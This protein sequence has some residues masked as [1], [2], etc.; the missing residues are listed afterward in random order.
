MS[1]P[2][3]GSGGS[4]LG[5]L[6]IGTIVLAVIVLALTGLTRACSFSPTSPSV[7]RGSVQHIDVAQAARDAARSVPFAVRAPAL[8]ADWIP[9]SSDVRPVGAGRAFRLGWVTPESG[10]VRLV[11]SNADEAALVASEEGAPQALGPVSAG[12]RTWTTYRGVRG[13]ALWV[14]DVDGVRWLLTG[15]GSPARFVQVATTTAGA[16]VVPHG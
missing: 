6:A 5:P 15:D 9:Q 14:T 10:F 13:E 4:T 8:P 11:Q 2:R 1:A 3:G 7:D 16:P 12:G